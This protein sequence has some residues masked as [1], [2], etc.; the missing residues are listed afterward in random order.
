[1]TN[2]DEGGWLIQEL[3]RSIADAYGWPGQR[4]LQVRSA[5]PMTNAIAT[6][7]VGY[8]RLRDF[9]AERFSIRR[10]PEGGL[11]WAR[12]GR[13]GRDLLPASE[14]SLFSPDSVMTIEPM[15]QGG[16]RARTLR[17]GFGGGVNIAERV[18]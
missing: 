11:Y 6:R 14:T 5:I 15:E 4:P 2:G 9:P 13:V 12:E 8:Y 16:P 18:E 17:I 10:T 3:L 7:F 1:M